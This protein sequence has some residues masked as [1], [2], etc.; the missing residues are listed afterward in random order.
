MIRRV[1]FIEVRALTVPVVVCIK[2]GPKY[3]PE[4]VNRLWA[5]VQ[6]FLSRSHRFVCLTDN[7]GGLRQ[8]IE[9]LPLELGGLIGWWHKVALFKPP[10]GLEDSRLIFLDLDTVIVDNIDFLLDYQGPFGV[11]RDFYRPNGYGSAVMSIAPGYQRGIWEKFAEHPKLWMA[12]FAGDQDFIRMCVNGADLWQ[13]LYPGK[14]VSYK[15]HCQNG[16][17]HDARITCF[18]GEPKPADLRPENPIRRMWEECSSFAV[19]AAR[20]V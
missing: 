1:D 5:G 12:E 11:L 20:Q 4:Y 15:V 14:I 7:R 13:D 10:G 6:R 8:E 2:A 9:T 16:I 17:P 3:G 18:H 19:E